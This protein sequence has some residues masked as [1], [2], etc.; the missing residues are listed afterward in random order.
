MQIKTACYRTRNI[1]KSQ[2]WG[3]GRTNGQREDSTAKPLL[4]ETV[5]CSNAQMKK[6]TRSY[7]QFEME[8]LTMLHVAELNY[9]E[10]K[11]H[12]ALD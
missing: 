9:K 10:N 7:V 3:A 4:R 11:K 2:D 8:A 12:F 5:I 6:K 1:A